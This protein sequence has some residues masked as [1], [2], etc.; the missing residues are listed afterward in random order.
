MK[1]KGD[2]SDYYLGRA[3][4]KGGAKNTLTFD[5]ALKNDVHFEILAVTRS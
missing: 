4:E 1:G 3:N 5:M 2:F